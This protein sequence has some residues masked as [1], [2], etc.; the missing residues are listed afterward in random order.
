VKIQ[1]IVMAAIT[2]GSS[3]AFADPLQSNLGRVLPPARINGIVHSMGLVPIGQPIRKGPTY[4]VLA[5]THRGRSVRII[6]DARFGNVLAIQRVIAVIPPGAYPTRQ[7]VDAAAPLR[8]PVVRPPELVARPPALPPEKPEQK[9]TATPANPNPPVVTIGAS[10]TKPAAD[11][12]PTRSASG[13]PSFPPV[14]S[15]E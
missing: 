7:P 5:S 8:T 2:L 10:N 11:P 3:C 4:A 6:V 15:F 9:Y 14:Q 1:A 12:K 13:S